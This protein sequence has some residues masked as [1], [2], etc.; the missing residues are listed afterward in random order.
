MGSAER[1]LLRIGLRYALGLRLVVVAMASLVSLLL[2]PAR[3]PVLAAAVVL[4]LNGWNAWYAYRKVRNGGIWLTVADVAVMCA[5][6]L[7]QVWTAT[8]DAAAAASWVFVA[9]A[10]TVVSYP[11]QLGPITL[12]VATLVIM[13]AYLAGTAVADPTGWTANV[14]VQLWMIMEA[15]LSFALYRFVRRGAR[16]ADRLVARNEELRRQAAIASARRAD[17][18]EYLAALHDTASA[19]LLMVGAGVVAKP[20]RWLSEQAARDLEVI[21]G[22]EDIPAGQVDLVDMLREVTDRAPLTITWQVPGAV[23]VPAVVAIALS[24]GTREALT[25]VVRHSG[26]RDAEIRV[27]H[28]DG[29]VSVEIV[30]RG[31]GFDPASVPD[32]RFGVA[33]SLVERMDRI[34]GNASVAS[35][36]GE[37]TTV[38]LE[39]PIRMGEPAGGDADIIANRFLRGLRWAMV[40]MNLVILYGLDLPKILANPE[41]YTSGA[42]QYLTLG[43]C[44]FISLWAGFTLWTGASRIPL[45]WPLVFLVF[46]VSILATQAVLPEQRLGFA[47][48]SEGDVAWSLVLLLLD[49]RAVVFAGVVVLQYALTFVQVWIGGVSAVTIAGAVNATVLVLAYQMAVGMIATVLRGIAVSAAKI[50]RDEEELRTSEAVADQLHGDRKERY[51]VLADT[52]APLLTGL[53][54]GALDPG[55]ATVRRQCSL[56]AA[57]MRRL[58]AEGTPDPLLH[59]LRGYI[60]LA[61]RNGVSVRFAERGQ[62]PVVPPEARRALT[63]PAVTMLTTAVSMARVTV[64]GTGESVTVSVVSD[65]PPESVPA[66]SHNGVTSS[67][68]HSGSQVWVEVTWMRGE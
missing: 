3:E 43:V 45:R 63:E 51:A 65:S 31:K 2:E 66:T 6:C 61:E 46:G 27:G 7:T 22:R 23:T 11:W 4:V 34:G 41:S 29:T 30:D 44:T 17:E 35:K 26:V 10:I 48:W 24:R 42:T 33:R 15:A 25:N 53:A 9:A 47:H 58:F 36:P 39:S 68:V 5:A 38:R 67:T 28:H 18:R 20:E 59:E 40:A 56:D 62:R 1:E 12:A 50:A 57:K 21:R 64:V 19:T 32:N 55:D 14:P 13:A 16:I 8:P 37:G 60:E 49:E 54:S 52:T